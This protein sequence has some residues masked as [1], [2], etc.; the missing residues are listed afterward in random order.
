MTRIIE[1]LR[2][3]IAL[4]TFVVGACHLVALEPHF[5][6]LVWPKLRHGL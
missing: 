4:I 2:Q 6:D 5:S 1:N 3:I